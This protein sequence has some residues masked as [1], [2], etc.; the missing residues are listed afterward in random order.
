MT[1]IRIHDMTTPPSAPPKVTA[2]R[3]RSHRYRERRKKGLRCVPVELR[4][5]AIDALVQGGVLEESERDDLAAL[6]EAVSLYLDASLTVDAAAN[7]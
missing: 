2:Q 5:E 1:D 4:R 7:G 6:Q 3:S